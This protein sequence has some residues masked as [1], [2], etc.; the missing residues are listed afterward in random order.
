MTLFRRPLLLFECV[1]RTRN[2]DFSY[3]SRPENDEIL[4]LSIFWC[5]NP[6]GFYSVFELLWYLVDI[7]DS[8][9]KPYLYEAPGFIPLLLLDLITIFF[10]TLFAPCD[11]LGSSCSSGKSGCVSS[12]RT[13][14]LFGSVFSGYPSDVSS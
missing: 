8:M 7:L 2:P 14:Q 3:L 9:K 6:L 5:R 13:S 12:Y 11:F 10:C 1:D 4:S